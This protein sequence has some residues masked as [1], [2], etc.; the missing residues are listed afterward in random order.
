VVVAIFE[1]KDFAQID[2]NSKAPYLN[3]LMRNAAVLVNAHA[4]AHPSQPNYPRCFP[5]P[6]RGSTA[7]A[8]STR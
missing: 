7:T 6:P 8:V 2:G 4:V 1:N 5:D 3:Q